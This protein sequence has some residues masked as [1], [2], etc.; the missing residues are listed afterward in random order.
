MDASTDCDDADATVGRV[1]TSSSSGT[2]TTDADVAAYCTSYCSRK[3]STLTLAG[4]SSSARR[5][6]LGMA[7]TCYAWVAPLFSPALTI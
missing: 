6:A 4:V 7:L 1:D 5:C 2:L 3:P